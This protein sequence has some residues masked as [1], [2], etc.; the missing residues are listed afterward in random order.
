M[1]GIIQILIGLV[2]VIA[3]IWLTFFNPWNW[4]LLWE[5]IKITFLGGAAWLILF[6]SIALIIVGFS[7][8]NEK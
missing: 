3:L 6:I 4:M 7:E 2:L 8:L 5:S 1:K